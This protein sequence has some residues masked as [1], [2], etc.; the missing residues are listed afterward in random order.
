MVTRIRQA[1]CVFQSTLSVRRA[2]AEPA[3]STNTFRFQSTLSVRRA[4]AVPAGHRPSKSFQS[5]LSVRRATE[6]D[7]ALHAAGE[8]SIHAL[9]EESD[10]FRFLLRGREVISIHALREESDPT[11]ACS[12]PGGSQFQ[13]TLSVRRATDE[14]A[15]NAGSRF[16]FNPRSPHGERRKSMSPS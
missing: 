10:L 3:K 7:D 1:G 13:S 8:I 11:C 9:R 16:H 4:T 5:T 14:S 12:R 15:H 2:T 6:A